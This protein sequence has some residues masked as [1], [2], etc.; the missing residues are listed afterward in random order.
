MQIIN[1]HCHLIEIEKALDVKSGNLE[2]MRKIPSVE[3]AEEIIP[4]VTDTEI[5][6]QMDE[7]GI[8]QTVLFA[9]ICPILLGFE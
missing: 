1:T 2:L 5:L 6:R 7:A 3:K 8:Q 4:F 9:L